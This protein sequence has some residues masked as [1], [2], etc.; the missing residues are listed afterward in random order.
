MSYPHVHGSV[1]RFCKICFQTWDF[2]IKIGLIKITINQKI[3]ILSQPCVGVRV[4]VFSLILTCFEVF[5]LTNS[6]CV[7]VC[8]CVGT[9]SELHT[10][11]AH[12]WPDTTQTQPSAQRPAQICQTDGVA[13]EHPEGEIWGPLQG[14]CFSL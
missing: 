7:F 4:C 5:P 1:S 14:E 9:W 12:S 3:C 11:P 8:V 10:V 6:V 13:E 2:D